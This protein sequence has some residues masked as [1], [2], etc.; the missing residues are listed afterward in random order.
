MKNFQDLSISDLL[1]ILR[2]RIGYL[3]VATT[4]ACVGSAIYIWKMPSIYQ[5]ETTILVA[6]RILPEDYIGSIV[7]DSVTARMD[8]VRQQLRSRTFLERI[9]Q[10]FQLA[11][12][13][14]DELER[15][16]AGVLGNIDIQVFSTNTLRLGYSATNPNIAHAIAQR[17]AEAVIQTNQSF[18]KEKVL[19]A[20]QVLDEQTRLAESDLAASESKLRQFQREHFPGAPADENVSVNRLVD[21]QA[22]LAAVQSGVESSQD[23]RASIDRRLQEHRRLKTVLQSP[24][25]APPP[26]TAPEPIDPVEMSLRQQVAAKQAELDAVSR[27][28]TSV[29]PDVIRIAKETRELEARL[30]NYLVSKIEDETAE[31]GGNHA[32]LPSS[33]VVSNKAPIVDFEEAEIQLEL[34][35]VDRDIAKR[36]RDVKEISDRIQLLQARLNPAPQVSRELTL[37]IDNHEAA[38]QRYNYLSGRKSNAELAASVDTNERNE[39]FR[40]IDEANLPTIPIRPNRP[41]L[42]SLSALGSLL[43]GLGIAFARE[44]CDSS[45]STEHEAASEL[46]LPV[47]T[48]PECSVSRKEVRRGKAIRRKA[49]PSADGVFDLDRADIRVRKTIEDPFAI[50]GEHFRMVRANLTALQKE[51]ALKTILIT[52][53]IPGEGKTFVGCCLAGILAR[54]PGKRVLLIDAD[55]RTANAQK[56]LGLE[57]KSPIYGLVE[58]LRGPSDKRALESCI[59]RCARSNLFFLPAGETADNPSELLSSSKLE[60]IIRSLAPS[61]D[62]IIVDSTPVLNLADASLA[63]PLCDATLLVASACKTPIKLVQN[64]IQKIGQQR[65]VSV[66]LNRVR[67]LQ[68][69]YYCGKYYKKNRL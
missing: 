18:R 25:P 65:T 60:H 20:D 9:V 69:A 27:R 49:P 47:V 46:K 48:I 30:N 28:Y 37:L 31:T 61:F 52:S 62:W 12:T 24:A 33:P 67:K 21:M 45:L 59:Q 53:A 13:R 16:I 5:S 56:V 15:A 3:V 50:T 4:L 10:E 17:L 43:L 40:V 6:D 63:I 23:L 42:M 32:R 2:R 66:V 26:P 38:K 34:D 68:S 55:L 8:F 64:S 39:T 11:G 1:R 36:R 51:R 54:E 41:L 44:Y 14:P 19:V 57:S 29:H 58:V 35:R 22:Q 7:R